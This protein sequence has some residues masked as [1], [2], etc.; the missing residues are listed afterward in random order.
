[1]LWRLLTEDVWQLLAVTS[2]SLVM[3]IA[4]AAAIKPLADGRVGLTDALTL[5]F[6]LVVPMLQFALPFAAGFAATMG[7]HRFAADN[8]A[9]AAHAGGIGH[10]ALLTP[11]MLTG[12]VLAVVLAGLSTSL[13][14]RFLR[15]AERVVTRDATRVFVTPIERGETVKIGSFDIYAERVLRVPVDASKT[16]AIDHLALL[17]VF[18]M[19]SL[20]EKETKQPNFITAGRVDLWVFDRPGDDESG[21]AVQLQFTGSSGEVRGGTPDA[22]WW[23][24]R[25]PIP[26]AFRDDPK[27]LSVKELLRVYDEPRRMSSV[28]QRFR[29]LAL[30]LAADVIVQE[31]DRSMR[32]SG[33]AVLTG[34]GTEI[35]VLGSGLEQADGKWRVL[36]PTPGSPI[37]TTL[38]RGG[39]ERVQRARGAV[40]EVNEP[41]ARNPTEMP[42]SLTLSLTGVET[43]SSTDPSREATGVRDTIEYKLLS[44]PGDPMGTRLKLTPRELLQEAREAAPVVKGVPPT[45][46]RAK[47]IQSAAR[48]LRSRIE[49]LRREIVSKLHEHAAFSVACFL[50]VITG[51]VVAL[52]MRD[53]LALPVYLWSFLPA[54]LT[55]ITISAGQGLTHAIGPPGLVLLWG[56]VAMLGLFTLREYAKLRRH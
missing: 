54:L 10:R 17:N 5:T 15:S 21:T 44:T 49:D 40:I 35:V 56:G 4:F 50:M 22:D 1:M 8:E 3:L 11:A 9:L 31:L 2:M 42:L 47:Q 53:S 24:H 14:P 23:T 26:G 33:H 12:L 55:V 41:D 19:E 27:F 37:T 20:G 25:L 43:F 51:A 45:D 52:R 28:E 18:A 48:N 39:D 29:A 30:R 34:E 16:D 13:I 46:E 6:L 32:R 36:P 38:R 7:Y